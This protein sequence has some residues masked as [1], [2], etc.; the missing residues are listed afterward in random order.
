MKII[1]YM[2]PVLVLVASCILYSFVTESF[3]SYK[4][5]P[6][7]Y[8]YTGNDLLDF[9]N[10]PRYRK[11]YRWPFRYLSSYPETHYSPFL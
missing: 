3:V 2:T 8:I 5:F 4:I 7:N 11:P 6:F 10:K 9:Y 1:L